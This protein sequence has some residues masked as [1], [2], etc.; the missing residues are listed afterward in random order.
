MQRE[1]DLRPFESLFLFLFE[2]SSSL[3]PLL[4]FIQQKDWNCAI[5]LDQDSD[6]THDPSSPSELP[7][8]IDNIRD[9]LKFVDNIPLLVPL[10]YDS[11][12]TSTK[13]MIEIFQEYNEVVLC[14]GDCLDSHNCSTFA[15]ADVSVGME[16]TPSR[17]VNYSDV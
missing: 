14:I 12:P 3:N 9:H 15:I 16:P 8:G 5:S 2:S 11:T 13:G 6:I 10:F 4:T 17:C 1:W 7:R